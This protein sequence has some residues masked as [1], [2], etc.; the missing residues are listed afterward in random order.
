MGKTQKVQ[1]VERALSILECFSLNDKE[2]SIV[3][4]SQ[5]VGLPR[6]T[7]ARLVYTLEARGYL[8]RKNKSSKYILGMELFRLGIIVQNNIQLT[9]LAKPILED[10]KHKTNETVYLDVLDGF[11]RL[12]ILSSES[13]QIIRSVVPSGQSSPL[14]AGSDG[15]VLLAYQPADF[16]DEFIENTGLQAF[17]ENTIADAEAL[18]SEL[19]HIRK[20]GYSLSY[21]EFT[22]DSAGI[23][24]PIWDGTGK[25]VAG[26]S[27]SLP[28]YRATEENIT[29]FEKELQNAAKALSRQLGADML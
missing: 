8:K 15:K 20:N 10:L 13:D 11:Q 26:I 18:R 23:S 9:A 29:I 1:S 19:A 25:V 24:C 27:I 22:P 17:T 2:L 28:Q 14:H 3:E 12:C 7:I 16:I 6:P 4:I 5:K 21:G